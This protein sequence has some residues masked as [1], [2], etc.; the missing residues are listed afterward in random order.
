MQSLSALLKNRREDLNFSLE[1]VS[2]QTK[3]R[4]EYLKNLEEGKYEDFP[5]EVY[6]K[7]FLKTY[8]RFLN[9]DNALV[10]ALYRR[11]QSVREKKR[12]IESIS[13]Q[14]KEPRALVT[15]KRLA[16]VIIGIIL[17]V[18]GIFVITQFTKLTK[19]PELSLTEPIIT[20]KD[21]KEVIFSTSSDTLNIAG[22]VESG[23]TVTINGQKVI[24][25]QLNEFR[26][27][28]YKI[29]KEKMVLAVNAENQFGKRSEIVLNIFKKPAESLSPKTDSQGTKNIWVKIEVLA[30]INIKLTVDGNIII[31]RNVTAGS[32]FD[33]A[34]RPDL[35]LQ[36]LNKMEITIPN[37]EKINLFLN[38]IKYIPKDGTTRWELVNGLIVE[39]L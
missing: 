2:D 5:S 20:N 33:E 21:D 37:G 35:A 10:Q 38:G 15:R 27:D 19:S 11:E 12:P 39:Q 4:I 36:A 16:V 14:F 34:T 22:K 3:I 25:N 32:I 6:L 23:S 8:A 26:I 17:I 13:K 9:L 1:T 18:V 7:G 28:S 30:D 31:N 24:L 29:D